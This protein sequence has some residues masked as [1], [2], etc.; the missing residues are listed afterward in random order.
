MAFRPTKSRS[1]VGGSSQDHA[2]RLKRPPRFSRISCRTPSARAR[3]RRRSSGSLTLL[4]P[5]NQ[6]ARRRGL[7]NG[8][9]SIPLK[10]DL[11]IVARMASGLIN[12]LDERARSVRVTRSTMPIRYSRSVAPRIAINCPTPTRVTTDLSC[13]IYNYFCRIDSGNAANAVVLCIL[14]CRYSHNSNTPFTKNCRR[15]RDLHSV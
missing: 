12:G 14:Q 6:V 5:R 15:P 3:I 8:P 4:P 11:E 2:T 1:P 13:N 9:A 7:I 10:E